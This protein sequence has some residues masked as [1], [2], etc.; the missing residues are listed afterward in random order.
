M[1]RNNDLTSSSILITSNRPLIQ[2]FS[3]ILQQGFMLNARLG[4][5][6]R[7]ILCKQFG[8]GSDYLDSRINT[9]FLDGKPVDDV[10]SA[11]VNAGSILAL[12]ASMPGFVGAALRKGGFYASMRGEI[13]HHGGPQ[14]AQT[15]NGVFFLKLYNSLI[16]EMGPVF[17]SQG[18]LLD[19]PDLM[20]VFSN[21]SPAFW[22][23]CKTILCNDRQ[24]DSSYFQTS[25]WLDTKGIIMLRVDTTG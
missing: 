4:S 20:S 2:P 3:Q 7:D 8:F 17:L 14:Q 24:I 19:A 16:L 11:I 6:I 18:I 23:A 21:R 13:T 10:D 25:E 1:T 22:S 5:T 9:I 12:S 15:S